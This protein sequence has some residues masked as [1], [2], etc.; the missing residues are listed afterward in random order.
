MEDYQKNYFLAYTKNQK[1]A[2]GRNFSPFVC[3]RAFSLTP[4]VPDMNLRL[5]LAKVHMRLLEPYN[6]YWQRTRGEKVNHALTA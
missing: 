1:M 5:I 3:G 4:S 6:Q 2:V